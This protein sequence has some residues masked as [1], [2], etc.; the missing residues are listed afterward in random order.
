[1][2]RGGPGRNEVERYSLMEK[3]IYMRIEGNTREDIVNAIGVAKSTYDKWQRT[4]DWKDIENDIKE[5]RRNEM[6]TIWRCQIHEAVTMVKRIA[7]E[8]NP[9]NQVFLDAMKFIVESQDLGPKKGETSDKEIS[10]GASPVAIQ[11]I[12]GSQEST[13]LRDELRSRLGSPDVSVDVSEE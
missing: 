6:R 9:D 12:Q 8:G 4:D 5:A 3:A 11:I 2:A 7:K 13:Q 10:G 1:M